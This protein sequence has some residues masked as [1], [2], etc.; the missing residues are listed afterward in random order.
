MIDQFR[1]HQAFS[2]AA[3]GFDAN[4]FLHRE[5]RERLLD[6]LQGIVTEPLRIVDLGAGT[7]GA[8]P[9][10]QAR[11]PEARILS[12]DSSEAMLTAGQTTQSRLCADAANLPLTDGCIDLVISNL[13][14]HHCPDPTAV[15][16]E[17][18]RV[19]A[20]HGVLL[21]TAFGRNCLAEL[22]RAWATA[23]RFTHI[24]P[25]FDI[26]D[27]GGLFAATGFAEPVLDCQTLTVTYDTL[28]QMMRELRHAG[29]TNATDGRNRGLT[30]R[31]AW[32]R[33]TAAYDQ[34]REPA[35]KLPVTLEIIFG[36]TW[37]GS[38]TKPGSQVEISIDEIGKL[39]RNPPREPSADT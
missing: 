30:G 2:R 31:G 8:T 37:A 5:I 10:L 9:A 13:M 36:V 1:I 19:L 17:A 4:D 7:G 39:L 26:Q 12:V 20:D 38:R 35:G 23:D 18:R 33:L 34:L 28:P 14:L 27:L 22:G 16:S 29:S 11:Y 15:L 25:F 21:L 32:R 6:R 24:A 3:A